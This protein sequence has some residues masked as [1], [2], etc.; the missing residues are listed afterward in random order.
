MLE[1][2]RQRTTWGC[3][4]VTEPDAGPPHRIGSPDPLQPIPG[5]RRAERLDENAAAV[6]I[7]LGEDELAEID[8]VIPRD[9]AVGSRY[10][11]EAM[12]LLNG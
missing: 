2:R 8:K 6:E 4:P 10:P 12:S 1:S 5:T 9:M 7:S 11:E 3:H